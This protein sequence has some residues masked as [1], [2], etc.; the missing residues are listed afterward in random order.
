MRPKFIAVFLGLAFLCGIQMVS[1]GQGFGV[2]VY[3]GAK[4]D[5]AI[6]KFVSG[7]GAGEAFCY[8]TKDSLEK[9]VAFYKKQP[10]F[11]LFSND[12]ETAMFMYKKGNRDTGINITI[13]NPWM[14]TKTGKMRNDTLISIVK[15]TT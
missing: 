13:Q 2:K 9:V 1:A 7:I 5:E 4:Y 15:P 11:E 8:V 10:S 3:D 6:S 12:K 14:D